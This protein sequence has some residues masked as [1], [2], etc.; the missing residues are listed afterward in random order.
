MSK[1]SAFGKSILIGDQFVLEEVP[2]IVSAIPFET[3]AKVERIEGKG[4]TLEDNRTEVP[5]YKEK[6]KEQQVISINRILEVMGIN[7]KKTPIK[8]T[9]GG[10]LLAGSGVGAS[11]ASCVSLARALN[12]EFD[13]GYSI[14]Q[15]NH[16][17]WEGEFSYHGTPSGVDNTASTY[18]GLLLYW[19]KDGKKHFEKI[20]P[21]NPLHIVLGNSGITANTA[22]LDDYIEEIKARDPASFKS[23]M[24]AITTQVYEMKSALEAGNLEKVGT[25]MTANHDILIALGLSHEKLIYLCNLALEMGALGA[26][27]TGG[28]RGGY[29]N[30]LTPNPD[31]QETIASVMETEGYKVIRTTIGT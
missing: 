25:I 24:V 4:W 19:I 7:V 12:A 27:V 30:A 15:I 23:R 10:S 18:G 9:Y 16:V 26:K 2:A 8:I 1:G 3:I 20:V 22:L 29:M 21:K 13:L 11:A 17:G 6:K 31:V 5:G 14:E 28:G